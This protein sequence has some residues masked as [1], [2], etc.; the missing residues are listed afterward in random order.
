LA[1][2]PEFAAL[3]GAIAMLARNLGIGV[4]AEGIE[5]AEQADQ[6]RSL[7]C[8]SG[9]GY[10]YARPMPAALVPAYLSDNRRA[11]TAAAVQACGRAA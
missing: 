8:Q 6:L 2:G 3:I 10:F 4:I 1:R 5:S 11:V 9:Q 7:D